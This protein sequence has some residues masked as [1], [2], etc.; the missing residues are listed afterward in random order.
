[1]GNGKPQAI[2]RRPR[3]LGSKLILFGTTSPY[4]SA[5]AI[6]TV[7]ATHPVPGRPIS[8]TAAARTAAPPNLGPVLLRA[9]PPEASV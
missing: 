9:K 1:M 7:I 8:F 6:A 3:W 2:L 4:P 5:N